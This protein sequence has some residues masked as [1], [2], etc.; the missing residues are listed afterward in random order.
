MKAINVCFL[1]VELKLTHTKIT[2]SEKTHLFMFIK[3]IKKNLKK[4]KT[5]K[6]RMRKMSRAIEDNKLAVK[7]KRPLWEFY[8]YWEFMCTDENND[9]ADIWWL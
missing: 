7:I 4:K 8:S 2:A 5:V 1:F 6:L 3:L 9:N